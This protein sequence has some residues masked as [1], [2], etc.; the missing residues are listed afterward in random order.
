MKKQIFTFVTALLLGASLASAQCTPDTTIKE[1]GYYP[2]VFDEAVVGVDYRQEL[3]IRVIEDTAVVYNGFPV[4]AIIDSINLL[5]I[6][7]LPASF[8]YQCYNATCS[9]IPTETGCAVLT[10]KATDS[11]IGVHPLE[12]VLKIHAHVFTVILAEDDTLRDAFALTVNKTGGYEI[13]K[14]D[15][16]ANFFP[17]PSVSGMFDLGNL[18]WLNSEMTIY[19][20]Y[21]KQLLSS[22]LKSNALDL[23]DLPA[24]MYTYIL[25]NKNNMQ[26]VG[27]LITLRN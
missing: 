9:F 4:T 6:I 12:L 5:E 18:N 25:T 10:G 16:G 20:Q 22:E 17:N 14:L 24:G 23:T 21:G 3:Q 7:G 8:D 2:E 15:Q 26:S 1:T 19:D 13:V 27:R 11:D